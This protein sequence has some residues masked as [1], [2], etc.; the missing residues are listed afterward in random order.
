[1]AAL[2]KLISSLLGVTLIAFFVVRAAPGDP[3]LLMVGERG[4][5]PVQYRAMVSRLGL[6]KPLV[7]Q[8]VRFIGA[9]TRGDLGTSIVTGQP[10]GSELL[11]RWPASI[12]LGA[13]AILIALL[14]GIPA[15]VIAA[16]HR[17]R[18]FDRVVTVGSLIGYAMPI[19]WLGLVLILLFSLWLGITPVSGRLDVAYD[20]APVTG[21]MIVDTLLPAAFADYGMTAFY[22]ALQHLALPALTMSV[23]PIAV[24]ARTSRSS[25]I[26]V[27]LED[28]IRSARAKGLDESRV[29]WVHAIRNA[30]LPIITVGGLFF[31][32]AAIAGAIITE[33]IFG[34]A[35]IG[36]Y[37]VS[38][39][40]ARD[41]PVIQ[42][43]I[44][45]IGV[46]V[47]LVNAAVDQL[48]RA[49]NPKMRA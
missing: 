10:V 21:F 8:Y 35:G 44:L 2:A 18:L 5:D 30:L 25:M 49:A 46:L 1:M 47:L 12:E 45:L 29:I 6:E 13:V 3:V 4:A 9:A 31:V 28:Y 41:Y 43:S 17:N 36:S 33:T 16:I 14:I 7:Y 19:F 32:N 20:V 40:N 37:I 15:G 24:F 26:E 34:W 27:L 48:Y 11:R 38:S 42:G 39:V 23:V 22:S